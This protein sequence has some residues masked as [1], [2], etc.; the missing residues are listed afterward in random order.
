MDTE[1]K[2][3]ESFAISLL[4]AG[5]ALSRQGD[6]QRV[7][8][9]LVPAFFDGLGAARILDAAQKKDRAGIQSAL[10]ILG[11]H[12]LEGELAVDAVLRTHLE[13]ARGRAKEQMTRLDRAWESEEK[14]ALERVKPE[15]ES[16]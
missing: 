10:A 1:R 3:S 5:V 7:I 15:R 2:L 13:I 8:N 9:A 4:L 11:V 14:R 16:A 6:S 12:V